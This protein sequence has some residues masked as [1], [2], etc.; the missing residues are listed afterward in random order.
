MNPFINAAATPPS[1]SVAGA[2]ANDSK[3]SVGK[4][5]ASINPP[6]DS[7]PNFSSVLMILFSGT[8]PPVSDTPGAGGTD[9]FQGQMETVPPLKIPTPRIAG[10]TKSA[11]DA[12]TSPTVAIVAN[13]LLP[14]V[15]ALSNNTQ[16]MAEP[17]AKTGDAMAPTP[18][19]TLPQISS[20]GSDSIPFE[21]QATIAT[22]TLPSSPPIIGQVPVIESPEVAAPLSSTL[23]TL[24]ETTS[25]AARILAPIAPSQTLDG[26]L[27]LTDM[28]GAAHAARNPTVLPIMPTSAPTAVPPA[29]RSPTMPTVALTG[30]PS[31][32]G[33]ERGL[34][35]ATDSV[36]PF[37]ASAIITTVLP[38]GQDQIV[39]PALAN[40]SPSAGPPAADQ[41]QKSAAAKDSAGPSGANANV[42]LT[43]HLEP[44]ALA[45]PVSPAPALAAEIQDRVVSHMD[46]LRQ[47]GRVEVQ[48]DLHPPEVGRVQLH[49]TLEDGRLNVRMLVQDE[50]AKRLIDQQIEPLR[51]R[52]S[53]MGVSVG[54]FDVRRD[55]NSPNPD[56][57]AAEP[58]AQA[59][60]TA[61]PA[62]PRMQKTYGQVAK[63]DALV[64]VLA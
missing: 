24:E 3:T 13:F 35:A 55:G 53:E 30:E 10:K 60:Q 50:N 33:H 5:S 36:M 45:E 8:Q 21:P 48:V 28:T 11:D 14:T 20:T 52:F 47:M 12:G 26:V 23:Q 31:G 32:S 19:P 29:G 43:T 56:Q 41:E 63:A 59:L 1:L 38:E 64:D 22:A 62:A 27:A 16:E 18:A 54:Q 4:F 44:K 61:K 7:Q 37:G 9:I 40:I 57:Q 49:L 6:S 25:D 51:V 34:P 17:A 58:S 42:A 2:Q 46:Q 15:P 39:L